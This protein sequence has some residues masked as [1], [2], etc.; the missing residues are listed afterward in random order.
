MAAYTVIINPRTNKTKHLLALIREM[1]KGEKYITIEPE[2]VPNEET[3]RAIEEV[4]SGKVT[5]AKNVDDLFR[6][7]NK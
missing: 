2:N 6:R 1:A 5:R 7:L 3:L 4:E